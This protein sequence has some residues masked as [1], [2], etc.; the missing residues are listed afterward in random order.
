[1]L[2]EL[3][4]IQGP[5]ER[6]AYTW[7][8]D[9]LDTRDDEFE[10]AAPI[11][12]ELEAQKLGGAAS[13]AHTRPSPDDKFRLVGRAR[14]ALRVPCS[15]CAEPFEIDVDAPFDLTYLPQA[16]NAG[17]GEHEVAEDDLSTAFYRGGT[18]DL[19]EL[20]REQFYLALPMKPL[21]DEACKGLCPQCGTNLNRGSCECRSTWEDPRLAGLKALLDN[22]GKTN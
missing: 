4:K 1:M 21:C 5:R 12:L 3:N 16:E 9:A 15:R 11:H 22:D 17:E 14:T 10:V 8:G 6:F 18:I 7:P 13:K 2:L 19:S 20:L